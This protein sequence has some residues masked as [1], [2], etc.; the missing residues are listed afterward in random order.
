M[1]IYY[2]YKVYYRTIG[3][4]LTPSLQVL[5]KNASHALHSVPNKSRMDLVFADFVLALCHLRK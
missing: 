2:D 4:D 3:M 1:K 5:Y